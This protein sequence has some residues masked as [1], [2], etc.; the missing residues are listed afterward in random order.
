MATDDGKDAIIWTYDL[1]GTAPPRRL[2][3][4]GQNRDPV[5][6][7]DSQRIVFAS[8]RDGD[9]GIFWQPADGSGS[10]ERAV[11]TEP[12]S[13]FQPESWTPDG[14][15]LIYILNPGG[16]AGNIQMISVGANQKS[17]LL[18]GPAGNP[19]LSRDGKW[20][21]YHS[22]ELGRQ[23]VYV[24]PF[25]LTGAK[26]QITT[27]GGSTPLWS[28]DGKQLFYLKD[29]A[30]GVRQIVSVDVQTQPR[31][32]FGKETPL[33]IEGIEITGARRYDITP[34]DKY[35]VVALSK[36]P[37][38]PLKTAPGAEINFTLN[39]FEELMQ[40]VPVH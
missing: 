20:L 10:A 33:P 22:R 1:A 6:T 34:D 2:T 12:R 16:A 19:N 23:E 5:W 21:A 29:R 26:Y 31:F 11:N 28:H 24:Q 32:S 37:T 17:K 3:F 7:P 13:R 35:F 38:D 40:R 25:P 15:T 4:G 27:T 14:K 36:A 9:N 30:G 18:V 39:W 8:D